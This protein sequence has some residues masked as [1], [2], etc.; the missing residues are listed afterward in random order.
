MATEVLTEVPKSTVPVESTSQIRI[1]FTTNLADFQLPQS[2]G[3]ILVPTNSTSDLRRYGLSTLVNHLLGTQ[4]PTPFDFLIS[5]SFLRSSLD[6]FLTAKGLSSEST[7]TIEY[8]RSVIPP[9]HIASFEHDDWVSSVDVLS[10]SSA[11]GI[12]A[13]ETQAPAPGHERILTGSYDGRLRVW[14]TSGEVLATSP[15]PAD[16]VVLAG[17]KAVKF[18][19]PSH[20][21]SAGLDRVIRIWN[22]TESE[23]RITAELDL[24]GHRGS[25]D[26]I[27]VHSPSNRIFS[28]STD[29]TVGL[30]MTKKSG[31]PAAPEGLINSSISGSSKRRKVPTSSNTPI[32][33]PMAQYRAH[34]APVSGVIFATNDA[35]VGY[36]TSLDH[37]LRTWD[38]TT[39]AL[40]DTRTTSHALLSITELP[41]L[42][43]L[44]TGTSA[45]HITLIDPRVSAT[46]VSS[47][48]LRGHTNAVVSLARDPN[49]AYSLVSGSHDGTCRVWDVRSTKPGRAQDST[50]LTEGAVCESMYTIQ[51]ES[52]KGKPKRT[53]GE[54]CKVLGVTWDKCVGIVSGGEDKRV[55]I[56][57]GGGGGE[58][59]GGQEKG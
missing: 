23:S 51:R 9:L 59:M 14:N 55:Q 13:G 26:D 53:A 1:Q 31:A 4:R 8:V 52:M 25:V 22:Y 39:S 47:M 12:W 33:G 42:H 24:Y 44:A 32:R 49:N 28:A 16:G 18:L 37:T 41:S 11:A 43:L 3:P 36:S 21:V 34:S 29:H 57:K 46:T 19:S 17:I 56:N 58:L 30:W 7:L 38:L 40:V 2:T 50:G 5:G 27:A 6:D 54:G 10:R 48:T 20:L 35:T 15:A 45:R